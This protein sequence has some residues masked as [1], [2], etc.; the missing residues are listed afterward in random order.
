MTREEILAM[1]AGRETDAL[2]AE[3][4][5]GLK[6]EPSSEHEGWYGDLIPIGDHEFI[7]PQGWVYFDKKY[8]LQPVP[9]YST[10]IAAAWKAVE[11]LNLSY[12]IGIDKAHDN[13]FWCW[14]DLDDPEDY[15][16]EKNY[17]ATGNTVPLAVCRAALLA[18]NV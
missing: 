13:V 16:M 9:D 7:D 14:F 11:K 3:K 12:R 2:I 6:P 15:A 4:V 18:V 17:Y 1:P 8:G 10:N 5:M